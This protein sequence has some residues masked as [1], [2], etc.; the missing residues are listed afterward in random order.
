MDAPDDV[1]SNDGGGST[2]R[3]VL[4]IGGLIGG[5]A[6]LRPVAGRIL[7]GSGGT[8]EAATTDSAAADPAVE[9]QARVT[10]S[11]DWPQHSADAGNAA[12][13]PDGVAPTG[14]VSEAWR[15]RNDRFHEGVAVVDGTVYV[16][17]KTLAA[18]DA[19]TGTERWQYRPE[20]PDRPEDEEGDT[21]E[22]GTPAVA[23]GLAYASVGF[24][25]Y[26][27]GVPGEMLVAVDAGS[28]E[29][30]W[31][32]DPAVSDRL[33]A[34]T[35]YSGAGFGEAIY[36]RD[37][38]TVHALAPDGSVRWTKS[39]HDGG[40]VYD[41]V[42][43][44]DGRVYV[45]GTDGVRAL[46]AETGEVAWAA[47][48]GEDFGGGPEAVVADGVLYVGGRDGSGETLVA[49]DA[50]TGEERWRTFGGG[51]GSG[52]SIGAASGDSVYVQT[53]AADAMA[54]D[55]ADGG[56]RWRTSIEQPERSEYP[57]EDLALVGDHLYAGAVCLD[58][59]DG[60]VV[61]KHAFDVSV[62]GW[63]FGAAS[64]GRVYV[65]GEAVVA[66]EGTTDGGG[67]G[68]ATEPETTNAETTSASSSSG[69][70]TADTGTRTA[71]TGTPGCETS[72]E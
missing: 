23:G 27:G 4:A 69:A 25:V 63:W 31:R 44:A 42:P 72:R 52:L 39:V 6:L 33:S 46:D 36:A 60:S 61:W 11:D 10:G 21:P 62:A 59:A 66:L 41:P 9:A 53:D 22:F 54:L 19:A 70:E 13:I 57:T 65:L 50:E 2:R 15:Y 30:R 40:S 55:A 20:A 28:G 58:P 35:V 49:L 32:Y 26:D 38:E 67:G 18:V 64:G 34:P 12:H 51:D 56:E 24:G 8:E 43:V 17:G 29:E 5:G 71:A 48:A 47:L 1:P 3:T 45:P 14:D 37:G 68:T 16:G 7:D